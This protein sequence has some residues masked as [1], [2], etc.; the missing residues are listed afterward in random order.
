MQKGRTL[1]RVLRAAHEPKLTQTQIAQQVSVQLGRPFSMQRYWQI[2]H[3]AGAVPSQ[4]EKAAI[5]KALGVPVASIA[6][7]VLALGA[8]S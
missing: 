8:V 6:W 2:E 5:A 1:L 3:G 4:D 7:P